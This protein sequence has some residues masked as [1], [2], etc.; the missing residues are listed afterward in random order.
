M[1]RCRSAPIWSLFGLTPVRRI[2]CVTEST[3][4]PRRVMGEITMC[5]PLCS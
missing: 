3:M 2:T 5:A 1:T 4:E